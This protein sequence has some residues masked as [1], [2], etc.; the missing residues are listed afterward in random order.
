MYVLFK[1][2]GENS[3]AVYNVIRNKEAIGIDNYPEPIGKRYKKNQLVLRKY[4]DINDAIKM[5][6]RI[7]ETNKEVFVIKEWRTDG[8]VGKEVCLE[9]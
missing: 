9:Q 8:G 2:D 3:K 1:D 5:Q 4:S 7:L 6:K